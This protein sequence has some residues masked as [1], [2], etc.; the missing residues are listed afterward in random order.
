MSTRGSSE[1]GSAPPSLHVSVR[2]GLCFHICKMGAARA[3]PA[4]GLLPG[5]G[6][7]HLVQPDMH[8]PGAPTQPSRGAGQELRGLCC[9]LKR[10]GAAPARVW[11]GGPGVGG[12][13]RTI[14]GGGLHREALLGCLPLRS[15]HQ[16][17]GDHLAPLHHQAVKGSPGG[18]QPPERWSSGPGSRGRVGVPAGPCRPE[19]PSTTATSHV[20]T[21]SRYK[22]TEMCGGRGSGIHQISK[23]RC[24]S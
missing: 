11:G 7:P 2:T 23:A 20:W 14:G 24:V 8:H 22:R 9:C 15:H 1:S 18:N 5:L 13:C 6:D 12:G 16:G 3:G 19:P 4:E 21:L 17:P 10:G